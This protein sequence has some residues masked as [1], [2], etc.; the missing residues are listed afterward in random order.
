M[1]SHSSNTE[2]PLPY[3]E[4]V[5]QQLLPSSERSESEASVKVVFPGVPLPVDEHNFVAIVLLD[6]HYTCVLH[7]AGG[8]LIHFDTKIANYSDYRQRTLGRIMSRLDG[9]TTAKVSTV[10]VDLQ[11]ARY[12]E[13]FCGYFAILIIHLVVNCDL[14]AFGVSRVLNQAD[15]PNLAK[16]IPKWVHSFESRS[17]VIP[18]FKFSNARR[19]SNPNSLGSASQDKWRQGN[20]EAARASDEIFA[21]SAGDVTVTDN[22]VRDSD[23]TERTYIERGFAITPPGNYCR[24]HALQYLTQ[25]DLQ[26]RNKRVSSG[27]S[28]LADIQIQKNIERRIRASATKGK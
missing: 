9:R 19:G 24:S 10:S 28:K 11:S 2:L 25:Y 26:E 3:L 4:Y 22:V 20:E 17:Q 23:S 5:I 12:F 15:F 14:T 16:M 7:R 1:F 27:A 21:M 6:N 18:F 8:P 13:T